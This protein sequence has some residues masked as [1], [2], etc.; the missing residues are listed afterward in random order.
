MADGAHS[1][2]LSGAEVGPPPTGYMLPLL[3]NAGDLLRSVKA[4]G[5]GTYGTIRLVENRRTGDLYALKLI[6]A[7]RG[8]AHQARTALREACAL[9]R[10]VGVERVS[11]LRGSFVM[12][13]S[14]GLRYGL[15]LDYLPGETLEDVAGA[16]RTLPVDAAL[17]VMASLLLSLRE[18]HA[19]GLAHRD[20][21]PANVVVSP[22]HEG[23]GATL[24]DFGFACAVSDGANPWLACRTD[25]RGTPAFMPPEVAG[26]RVDGAVAGQ[27]YQRGD[28]YSTALVVHEAMTGSLPSEADLAI[29]LAASCSLV[30]ARVRM[31]MRRM[32]ETDPWGRPTAADAVEELRAVAAWAFPPDRT[33]KGG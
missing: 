28:V 23:G 14:G 16:G 10:L 21:A 29:D 1:P 33:A 7:N 30:G 5:D 3:R 6:K 17:R 22:E 13:V 2:V 26:R 4:L 12:P 27:V 24:I 31:L 25:K 15:L 18:I 9:E 8:S 32:M 20:V 19:R 11:Q